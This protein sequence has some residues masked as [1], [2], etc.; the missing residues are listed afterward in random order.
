MR[1]QLRDGD[2]AELRRRVG[3]E[4]AALAR[5]RCRAVLL[6]GEGSAGVGQT[7]AQIAA[8]VG[9]SRQF[10]DE[11]VGRY[12]RQGLA[13]LAARTP[14]GRPPAL[15]AAEPATF[16]AR[17]KAGPTDKDGGKCTLR[18]GDA[19]RILAAEFGKP[20][21]LSTA[22]A[23]LHRAGLSH[24]RPRPRHR[25]NDPVAMAAW[26][27]AAPLLSPPNGP[28]TPARRYRSGS[29]TRRGSASRGR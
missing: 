17:I 24:L 21:A 25:K 13:G 7:R 6:A 11:W 8:A 28:C 22:Y 1:V 18:G 19:R 4:R 10:V 3:A 16:K 23:L 9:R 29:R 26:L 27:A 2:G 12:R 14:K 20:V 5:D 15:T